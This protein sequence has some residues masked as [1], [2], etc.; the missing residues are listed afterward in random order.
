M[1]VHTWSKQF[2]NPKAT[3][4]LKAGETQEYLGNQSELMENI[5]ENYG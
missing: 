3:E 2:G 5:G 1:E 4:G